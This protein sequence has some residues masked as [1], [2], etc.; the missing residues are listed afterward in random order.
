MRE[1][2]RERLVR[3]LE[4]RCLIDCNRRLRRGGV[5]LR[6]SFFTTGQPRPAGRPEAPRARGSR[7]RRGPCPTAT[8]STWSFGLGLRAQPRSPTRVRV[9]LGGGGKRF[10]LNERELGCSPRRGL[11]RAAPGAGGRGSTSRSG[12]RN[13]GPCRRPRV[14]LYLRPGAAQIVPFGLR[15]RGDFEGIATRNGVSYDELVLE[16]RRRSVF[17][18]EFLDPSSSS[19]ARRQC[20]TRESPRRRARGLRG[21]WVNRRRGVPAGSDAEAAPRQALDQRG[22]YRAVHCHG[23][24]TSVRRRAGRRRRTASR[25]A[26]RSS[27]MATSRRR[28]VPCGAVRVPRP[29]SSGVTVRRRPVLCRRRR[30]AISQSTR[31]R[32]GFVGSAVRPT[33][34]T[35]LASAP[36]GRA[37]RTGR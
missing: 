1:R 30:A 34:T 27:T 22:G 23:H 36:R 12:A 8:R 3:G 19:P 26:D 35:T 32:R 17:H 2:K 28:Q 18:W 9:G 7:R 4:R 13:D 6:V 31:R 11:R 24:I 14:R 16:D 37:H 15:Y 25:L 10:L 33:V 29:A 5:V 20:S 21:R